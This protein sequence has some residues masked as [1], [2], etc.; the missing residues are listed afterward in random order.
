MENLLEKD[1]DSDI[2][3]FNKIKRS[4]AMIV[5]SFPAMVSNV[6][7]M[8]V[9]TINAYYGGH[10]KN[11]ANLAAVGIANSWL[12]FIGMGPLICC[13]FGFFTLAAQVNGTQNNH[14]LKIICQRGFVFNLIIF[15]ISAIIL[16]FSPAI[17]P[18][19]GVPENVVYLA[20]PYIYSYIGVIFLE[21]FADMLK[22]LLN[23]QK[24]FSIFPISSAIATILHIIQCEIFT[25]LGYG[26]FS[27]G[28]SKFL[29]NIYT[30]IIMCSYMK[31]KKINGF[32]VESFE[33]KAFEKLKEYSENVIPSGLIS[34][35]EWM[36]FEIT[37]IMASN[38]GEIVL[39]SHTVFLYILAF[40]YTL[41]TGVGVL[42]ASELGNALG[43][44]DLIQA[45][46]LKESYNILTF[47]MILIYVIFMKLCFTS[48]V[49][50]MTDK[51]E[52]HEMIDKISFLSYTLCLFDFYQGNTAYALRATGKQNYGVK[53]YL[54]CYY[55]IGIPFGIIFGVLLNMTILGWF[56]GLHI[57]QAI[58]CFFGHKKLIDLKIEDLITEVENA[59]ELQV[60]N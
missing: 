50:I 14:D 16:L 45:R 32:L 58:F 1:E 47:I 21:M 5:L 11:V 29:A 38:F 57:S 54:I 2:S 13:N 28:L 10:M 23:A 7:S 60:K 44:K 19:L 33:K 30:L 49:R 56:G 4:L 36:A 3:L 18:L 25:K 42:Y 8:M 24:F 22:N 52:V 31:Y 35:V 51:L 53:L 37:T 9:W 27:L 41:F 55:G 34:Y 12:A 20:I 43:K 40:I 39:S 46:R 48:L 15:I 26:L 17:L 6:S 59:I